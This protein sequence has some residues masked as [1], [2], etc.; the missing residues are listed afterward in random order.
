MKSRN[1]KFPNGSYAMLPPQLIESEVFQRLSRKENWVL[2]RFYQKIKRKPRRKLKPDL[3]IS[4]IINNGEI[5]FTYAEAQENG[6][7]PS[8]FNRAIKKLVEFGFI[9]IASQGNTFTD[10]PN[11]YSISDRWKKYG[12]SDFKKIKKKRSLPLGLGFQ[13]GNQHNPRIKATVT[14]D[15]E[16]TVMDDSN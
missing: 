4:D 1:R 12:Q 6:V 10:T 11:Y 13:K 15:S 16:A 2:I 7:S 9:D 3:P 5:I 14:D 8:T